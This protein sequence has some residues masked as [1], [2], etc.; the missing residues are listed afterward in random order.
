MNPL[1]VLFI[2]AAFVN[3]SALLLGLNACSGG[4]SG[5]PG[6]TLAVAALKPGSVTSGNTSTSTI[7][8]TSAN[9]YAGSVTLS[10]S[11]A[12]AGTAAPS[13][14]ISTPTVMISNGHPATSTLTV[15]TS[16]STPGGN[17]T[18]SITGIGANNLAPAT[19]PRC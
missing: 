13:C 14:S 1:R 16:S 5:G 4:M 15:S 7:S 19:I 8:V 6:Y 11:I 2:F 12:N 9:G 17:Y 18:V 10:C 3:L